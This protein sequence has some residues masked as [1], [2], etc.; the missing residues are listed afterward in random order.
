MTIDKNK[1][2]KKLP[3]PPVLN[4]DVRKTSMETALEEAQAKAKATFKPDTVTQSTVSQKVN[5]SV[6]PKVNPKT[7]YTASNP[8]NAKL[9]ET[10]NMSSLSSIGNLNSRFAAPMSRSSAGTEVTGFYL[11]LMELL[12]AETNPVLDAV[13]ILP[14]DGIGN[15]LEL[16]GIIISFKTEGVVSA[17]TYIVE[18]S[19]EAIAPR[20]I[21][22][23]SQKVSVETTAGDVYD[24]YYWRKVEAALRAVHGDVPY[25][26]IGSSVIP[27]KLSPNNEKELR[28]M[29]Y[30]TIVALHGVTSTVTGQANAPI[31]VN[32]INTGDQLIARLD[33][34]PKTL[35]SAAGAIVRSDISIA[36][37]GQLTLND[38]RSAVSIVKLSDVDGF[39][40]LTYV[41]TEQ[42]IQA[43]IYGQPIQAVDV[44]TYVPRFIMTSV[45]SGLD[46]ITLELQL[47][48]ISTAALLAPNQAYIRT[49]APNYSNGDKVDLRDIGAIGYEINFD[50][51]N[52]PNAELNRINT[53]EDA[54]NESNLYSLVGQSIYPDLLYSMDIPEAGDLTW[55]QQLFIGAANG[56]EDC[57]NEIL[58]SAEA[59]TDGHFSQVYQGVNPM[60]SETTRVHLGNYIDESNQQK[61]IRELGYLAML[62]ILGARD[63]GV[64]AAFSETYD[65]L[66]IDESIRMKNRGNIIRSTLGETVRITGFARRVT[67]APD[68]IVALTVALAKAG[69]SIRPEGMYQG[70]VNVARGSASA[71]GYGVNSGNI[72]GI[73]NNNTPG[74]HSAGT[75]AHYG[76]RMNTAALRTRY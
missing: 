9:Q 29:L 15:Q 49:F 10:Q 25:L 28:Q 3:K 33:F 1:G 44:R 67:F 70:A 46:T 45:R 38:S 66:D 76:P 35:T 4:G 13:S 8:V 73:F 22:V 2:K 30:N 74:Y 52:N 7:N 43:P 24:E 51:I 20:D 68:F 6:N 48:G 65:R 26:D 40:D 59:L 75:N 69:L 55:I 18:S 16:S 23:G 32:D 61:D 31:S 34:S 47:L 5:P 11:K 50:P 62:N 42:A 71:R 39:I 54:F 72:G 19:G 64:V 57:I 58:N 53:K 17:F 60:S 36:L 56:E 12:K 27:L 63:M 21:T 14:L 41:P 37:N